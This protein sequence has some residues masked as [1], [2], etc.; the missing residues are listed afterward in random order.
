MQTSFTGG[1]LTP[2]MVAVRKDLGPIAQNPLYAM[3]NTWD[4]RSGRGHKHAVWQDELNDAMAS[5]GLDASC[6]TE[7]PPQPPVGSSLCAY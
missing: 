1:A 5:I 2:N 4:V 3:R 7:E 6:I